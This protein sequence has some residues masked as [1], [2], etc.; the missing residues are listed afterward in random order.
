ML[1]TVGLTMIGFMLAI[2]GLSVGWILRKKPLKGSCGG[3]N[4]VGLDG[5]CKLCGAKNPA[6]ECKD[7]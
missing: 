5:E 6:I 7:N 2:L 4:A 3:L 1:A